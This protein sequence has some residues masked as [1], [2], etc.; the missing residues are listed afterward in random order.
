[1]SFGYEI[2]YGFEIVLGLF[3]KMRW[4]LR[5][6]LSWDEIWVEIQKEIW[7]EIAH[8]YHN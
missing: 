3:W 7:D 4:Y 8:R 6:D 1:M 5:L 2:S